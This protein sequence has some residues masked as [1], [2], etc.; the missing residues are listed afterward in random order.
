MNSA[1]RQSGYTLIEVLIA[2]AI[3]SSMLLLAATGLNQGL[4][5]YRGVL[6][7]GIDFW[8]HARNLWLTKS[9]SGMIDYYVEDRQKW[10]PYFESGF[11]RVSYTTLSPLMG[12]MPVIAWIVKEKSKK[13]YSIRYYE[14]PLL[15]K[16]YKEIN[17]DFMTGNYKKGNSFTIRENITDVYFECFVRDLN[18]GEAEWYSDYNARGSGV[19]PNILKINYK[20]RGKPNVMVYKINT[21]TSQKYGDYNKLI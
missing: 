1:N 14:L 21:N 7:K 8:V 19:L 20:E 10:F 17:R 11:G 4:R 16:N 3:F 12:D 2:T 5:N 13:N 9:I 6:D 18:T 15:T